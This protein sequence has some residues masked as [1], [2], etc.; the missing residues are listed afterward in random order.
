M[1]RRKIFE[2]L[3]KEL[4]HNEVTVLTGMRRVGKTTLV[5]ALYEQSVD[6]RRLFL[7]L[8]DPLNQRLFE[9]TSYERIGDDL[10][11]LAIGEGKLTVFLDEIQNCRN[12]PSI[13]KYL[14]D[15]RQVKF[16]LTGSA[17]FYLK[18]LFSESLAGRKR[19]LEIFPLDFEEFLGFRAP[20]LKKPSL[21][22]KVTEA[23]F[24]FLE[25]YWKEYVAFGGFPG[26]VITTDLEDK[27]RALADIYTSY[28]QKE[29]QL[30]ADFRKMAA[31]RNMMSLLGARVGSKIDVAK[32]ASELGI[33]RITV[34]DYADFLEGTYFLYQVHRFGKKADVVLRGQTKPYFCDPGILSHL[35]GIVD[36]SS[37]EN[38]VFGLL[39]LT[40][41]VS[42]YQNRSGSEIDFICQN[43]KE[44]TAF[45]VKTTA[46][47]VDINKLA[48]QAAKLGI[49]QYYLVSEKYS[50]LDHVIF[51]FQL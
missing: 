10:N 5:R 21:I 23:M 49:D 45:E 2:D 6:R 41:R 29:I 30:L 50:P 13:V 42:Y 4:Q 51:P 24:G 37:L 8:E 27:K 33:S 3:R 36:T 17:S 35:R 1:I 11:G 18:H 44:I 20:N 46:Y 38:A 47:Q 31:I 40:G 28:Y 15:H 9:Q 32:I 14:F 12:L 43:Q 19:I 48:R 26:V 16:I 22:D 25:K 7:D 34:K 39:R